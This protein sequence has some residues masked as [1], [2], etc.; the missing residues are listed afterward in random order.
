MARFTQLFQ[1][2]QPE[3]CADTPRAVRNLHIK[4]RRLGADPIRKE[5]RRSATDSRT[6]RSPP[7]PA[8]PEGGQGRTARGQCLTGSFSILLP[9]S[10]YQEG[11]YPVVSRERNLV[12]VRRG[13]KEKRERENK[14]DENAF[15]MK[16]WRR[17]V[18]KESR[19]LHFSGISSLQNQYQG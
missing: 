17:T 13:G 3:S 10:R 9:P 5:P 11:N 8:T 16:K 4:Y 18:L 7:S 15:G 12:M 19:K 14:R 1:P 6:W 2:E